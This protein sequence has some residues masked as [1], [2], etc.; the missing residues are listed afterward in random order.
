MVKINKSIFKRTE[1]A[2]SSTRNLGNTIF[3]SCP[4]KYTDLNYIYIYTYIKYI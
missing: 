2:E 1:V 4:P 3:K